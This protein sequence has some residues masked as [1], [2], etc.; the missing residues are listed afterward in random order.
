LWV[1][2]YECLMASMANTVKF[3]ANPLVIYTSTKCEESF[4]AALQRS[5]EVA[6]ALT[7]KLVKSS[8]FSYEQAWHRFFV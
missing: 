4:L 5:D 2:M 8:I 1:V 6:E 7:V 3:Q